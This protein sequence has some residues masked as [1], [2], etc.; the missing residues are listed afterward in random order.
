[1]WAGRS[2]VTKQ[3]FILR[4]RAA[5]VSNDAAD[6]APL[7]SFETALRAPAEDSGSSPLQ[8]RTQRIELFEVLIAD[9]NL[10]AFAA[11]VDRHGKSKRIR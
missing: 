10:A 8:A 4:A 2:K 9:A 5:C 6:A 3:D 7:S 11:T 1:V